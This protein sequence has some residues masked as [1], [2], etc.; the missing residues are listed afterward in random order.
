M[1]PGSLRTLAW[2]VLGVFLFAPAC[3]RRVSAPRLESLQGGTKV[4]AGGQTVLVAHGA[5]AGRVLWRVVP[6]EAAALT[7]ANPLPLAGLADS[8]PPP[9]VAYAVAT[10]QPGFREAAV[11]AWVEGA[12]PG[13]GRRLTLQRVEGI[14][15]QLP[16][17]RIRI[18][19]GAELPLTAL[20][21]H[22]SYP[23]RELPQTVA[24]TAREDLGDGWLREARGVLDGA[25][26]PV[27]RF[28][29]P[30]RTGRYALRVRALADPAA[31]AL[32]EVDVAEPVPP[33]RD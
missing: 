8:P 21:S 5:G 24:W 29:G 18:D 25:R 27:W 1:P 23:A 19:A 14:Q 7:V 32:L 26:L 13:S 30:A 6:T 17:A 9:F 10:L 22:P 31:E 2:A 20:V 28:K 15:V 16:A 33:R 12:A 3:L 4:G 11:E